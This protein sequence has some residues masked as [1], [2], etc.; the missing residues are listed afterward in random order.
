MRIRRFRPDDADAIA[1][2]FHASVRQGGLRHY[3]AEQVAAWSPAR[4]DPARFVAKAADRVFL[5]AEDDDGTLLGYGDLEPDGHIDHLFCRPDRIG[6]GVGH[7]LYGA[8]EA[9]AREAALPRLY[10]EASDSALPLF[11]RHGFRV[12][13][14]NDMVLNGVAIHNFRMSKALQS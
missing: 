3:T 9:A 5:L 11:E 8:I 12:D 7:A 4:P 14:R 2:L 10:V 1:D 13:S 6:T